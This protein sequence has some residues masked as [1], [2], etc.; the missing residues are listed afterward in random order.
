MEHLKFYVIVIY[1]P[2]K[3]TFYFVLSFGHTL[4]K[5]KNFQPHQIYIAMLSNFIS[6][7]ESLQS[8]HFIRIKSIF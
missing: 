8:I 5:K 2:K 7:D 6:I 1:H 3:R 4:V